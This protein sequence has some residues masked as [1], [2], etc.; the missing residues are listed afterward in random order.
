MV[1]KEFGFSVLMKNALLRRNIIKKPED[2]VE[3]PISVEAKTTMDQRTV[4]VLAA[5]AGSWTFIIIFTVILAVLVGLNVLIL[6]KYIKISAPYPFLIL[7]MFISILAAIQ[8]PIILMSKN[9]RAEGK[10]P[11]LPR[12]C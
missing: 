1:I 12:H 11:D 10:Q 8:V 4:D 9:R 5:F 2:V 3:K 6:V 7:N